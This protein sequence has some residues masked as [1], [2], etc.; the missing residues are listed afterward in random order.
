MLCIHACHDAR[1]AR[2]AGAAPWGVQGGGALLAGGLNRS[3][4]EEA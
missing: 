3:C 1:A 2:A 4:D